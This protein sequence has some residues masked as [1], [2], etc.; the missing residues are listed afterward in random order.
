M[1]AKKSYGQHFLHRE[2]IAERIADSLI[3]HTGY[4]KVLEVGPGTGNLTRFLLERFGENLYAVEAD[5]DMVVYQQMH[6]PKLRD[7]LFELDFLKLDFAS[8]FGDEPFGIIGNYPYNISSQIVFRMLEHK[9]QVPEL[10]GMFQKEMALR[11][12]ATHGNK[13]F[14]V[15]S[16]L[17]Q[18][19][20]ECEYL[21]SVDKSAFNPP[22]KVQSGVI[23]LIRRETP[24]FAG[25]EQLLRRVVKTTFN[26]RRK[27]LR[28]TLKPMFD[29]P[30]ILADTFF[31]QR[32]EQLSVPDFCALCERVDQQK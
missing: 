26:Q 11:I 20:Y 23:R 21:F 14:G 17:A 3:L 9:E 12:A 10:V 15:L 7:R 29:N 16:V 5:H 4:K 30:E 31:N 24:L 25:D 22:P 13:D 6:F 32:P 28:N 18:V 1:K 2:D 19:Y 27:M 8:I